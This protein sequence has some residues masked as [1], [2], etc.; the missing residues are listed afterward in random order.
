MS[1]VYHYL[2][3]AGRILD[4]EFKQLNGGAILRQLWVSHQERRRA[5]WQQYA[6]TPATN[7]IGRVAILH[8]LQKEDAIFE[9]LA[10][11]LKLIEPLATKIDLDA[12]TTERKE[13]GVT[14]DVRYDDKK[15][16]TRVPDFLGRLR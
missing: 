16:T 12:K 6:A 4:G 14:F 10:E 7:A 11:R 2:H 8:T 9:R 3:E 13:L 1:V 15:L 5:L